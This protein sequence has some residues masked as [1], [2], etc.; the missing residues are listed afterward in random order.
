MIQELIDSRWLSQSVSDRLNV[1]YLVDK[2]TQ[3]SVAFYLTDSI[4][5]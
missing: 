5:K 2:L 4:I 3:H 1:S